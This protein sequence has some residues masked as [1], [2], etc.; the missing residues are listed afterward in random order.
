MPTLRGYSTKKPDETYRQLATRISDLTNQWTR[1]CK[2]MVE[3]IATEQVLR[4]LPEGIQVWV[5]ERKPKTAAEAGQLA[6]DYIQATRP[7]QGNKRM[8]PVGQRT[9][10][11]S[12]WRCFD[13]KQVGHLARD[14]PKQQSGGVPKVRGELSVLTV[15]KRDLLL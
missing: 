1:D 6:E 2:T 14:C 3:L 10:W 11:E 15:A 12:V 13:C 7:L 4:A 9:D 8:E 5:H